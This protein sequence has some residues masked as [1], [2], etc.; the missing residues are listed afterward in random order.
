MGEHQRAPLTGQ[1]AK[2]DALRGHQLDTRGKVKWESGRKGTFMYHKAKPG[3]Y[4]ALRT[5]RQYKTVRHM[6][7]RRGFTGHDKRE[8]LYNIMGIDS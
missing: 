1:K 4:G 5:R 7:K 6:L 2:W 8:L 3:L